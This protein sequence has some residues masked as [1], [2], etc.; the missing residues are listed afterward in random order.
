MSGTVSFTE[1]DGQHAELLAARTVLSIFFAGGGKGGS[2]NDGGNN[3]VSDL[4]ST[5]SSLTQTSSTNIPPTVPGG[6]A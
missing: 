5:V 3:V 6:I 4:T 1:F 2:A